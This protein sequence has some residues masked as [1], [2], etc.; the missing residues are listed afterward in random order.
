MK[1]MLLVLLLV[2]WFISCK[3]TTEPVASIV[4]TPVATTPTPA[5]NDTIKANFT[6]SAEF[7]RKYCFP[8]TINAT[9]TSVNAD[10][11]IWCFIKNGKY[12]VVSRSY[13]F[14]Y[15]YTT[16]TT[17]TLAL[18]AKNK[19]GKA[20]TTVSQNIIRIVA[21]P[22][23]VQITGIT[24]DALQLS[25]ATKVFVAIYHNGVRIDNSKF[26]VIG[27]SWEA[28][29]I[30]K[31]VSADTITTAQLPYKFAFPQTLAPFRFNSISDIYTFKLYDT[32]STGAFIDQATIKINEN[33]IN[34]TP[35]PLP[36]YFYAQN[37]SGTTKLKL[38]INKWY[39]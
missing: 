12:V 2:N 32:D 24:I 11:S 7:G 26:T 34:G 15:N 8:C 36:F 30:R 21:P 3:K 4:T 27:E 14:A 10:S 39:N 28:S 5:V 22:T 35:P 38:K 6:L 16:P 23:A 29:T 20:D 31:I 33:I 1:K 13:H 17:D 25:N 37:P 18:I 9:N 19:N